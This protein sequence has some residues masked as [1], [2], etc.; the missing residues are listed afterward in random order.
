MA[1]KRIRDFLCFTQLLRAV[2]ISPSKFYKMPSLWIGC[3]TT[4]KPDCLTQSMWQG[5]SFLLRL[6]G[7][8]PV[9]S[10]FWSSQ[11]WC[12]AHWAGQSKAGGQGAVGGLCSPGRSGFPSLLSS[13]CL[14]IL[15]VFKQP[16]I[17]CKG[18]SRGWRRVHPPFLLALPYS[19]GFKLP[20]KHCFRSG[21]WDWIPLGQVPFTL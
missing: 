7:A 10:Q 20:A 5:S 17:I 13:Y 3:K 18:I 16:E 19:Y 8:G 14:K 4:E 9:Q 11:I 15:P 12:L 1:W 21:L 2:W 6:G